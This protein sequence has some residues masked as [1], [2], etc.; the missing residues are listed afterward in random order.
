M[1]GGGGHFRS[2]NN[3]KQIAIGL[4]HTVEGEPDFWTLFSKS[5]LGAV[6]F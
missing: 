5:R 1:G 2:E 4:M 6:S 3:H